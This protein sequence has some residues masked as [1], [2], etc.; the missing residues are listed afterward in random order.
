M[1]RHDVEDCDG[2]DASGMVERQPVGNAAAAIVSGDREA[3]AAEAR[4]QPHHV[5]RHRALRIRGV[6]GCRRRAAA[7]AI[8]PEVGAHD[9]A[10]PRQDRRD[11]A[12]HQVRLRK[13]MQEQNWR[14]GTRRAD[15]DR[16]IAEVDLVGGEML[17]GRRFPASG[18]AF[19]SHSG[20]ATPRWLFS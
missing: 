2:A 15:E 17:Q 3:L 4:H 13:S 7:A 6:I 20:S 8:A 5:V 10:P 16:G 12:P 1:R 14:A 11:R 19:S 18:Y 9:E